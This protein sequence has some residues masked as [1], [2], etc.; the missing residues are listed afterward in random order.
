MR[1]RQ[2]TLP[3]GFGALGASYA[4]PLLVGYRYPAALGFALA[5]CVGALCGT[6]VWVGTVGPSPSRRRGALVGGL[7][8]LTGALVAGPVL[9]VPA[10][11]A[12]GGTTTVGTL[13]EYAGLTTML[14]ALAGVA[15]LPVAVAF[16]AA[17]TARPRPGAWRSSRLDRVFEAS[18]SATTRR[19]LGVAVGVLTAACLGAGVVQYTDPTSPGVGDGPTYAGP[20]APAARQVAQ[21][22][23]RTRAVSHTATTTTARYT[24]N[25]SVERYGRTTLRVEHDRDRDLVRSVSVAHAGAATVLLTEDAVWHWRGSGS[26]PDAMRPERRSSAG[27][28]H[29]YVT[30]VT[31]APA[32]VLDRTAERVVVRYPTPATLDGTPYPL[33][34]DR[35]VTIDRETGRLVGIETV[36]VEDDGER[37]VTTTRFHDYGRTTITPPET[38][39]RPFAFHVYDLLQGPLNGGTPLHG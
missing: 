37:V 31:D 12:D 36:R 9:S 6:V 25:G 32:T 21:A 26:N 34:G 35:T 24:A 10:A 14:T 19:R 39:P 29:Y 11:V 30:A 33:D 3:L 23:A 28:G 18:P 16:G 15:A 38:P 17:V 2:F 7:A 13:A 5:C 20:N 8:V 22:Q 27:A 4:L 1:P